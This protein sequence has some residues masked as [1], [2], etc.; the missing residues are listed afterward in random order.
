MGVFQKNT[1]IHS[2]ENDETP[3][4]PSA[5]TK[6]KTKQKH[7]RRRFKK[8]MT[9]AFRLMGSTIE[10]G[11]VYMSPTGIGAMYFSPCPIHY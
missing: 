5:A 2:V 8:S 11:G 1:S 7:F 9:N 4:N 10:Q 6:K 3:P